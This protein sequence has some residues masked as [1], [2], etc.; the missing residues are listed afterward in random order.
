MN[1]KRF[2]GRD[3]GQALRAVRSSL[4]PDA[5][6]METKNLSK[7]LGGGIEITALAE[8]P[9]LN[10][11]DETEMEGVAEAAPLPVDEIREELAALRSMLRWLAPGINHAGTVSAVLLKHGFAP[12]TIAT[13]TE[14]MKSIH[15]ADDR[16]RLYRALA[17]LIP[18]GGQINAAGD[19]LAL[20]GPAGV[21]KTTTIIKLTIFET[22]RRSCR[23]GWV[24]TDQRRLVIGDP[25]A[26]YAGILGVHYETAANRKEL[27]QT[28][29][30]MTDLDLVLVDTAGV[31]PRDGA[32]M[33]EL[34]QL[35]H[36][37]PDLR[38]ALL[39]SAVTNGAD[40][41]D[42][43]AEYRKAALHS[44]IFT[45]IDE[46]RFLGPVVSTALSVG[47]PLSYV[48]LGQNFVGD[49]EV[50]KPAIFA[51]LILPGVD[52]HD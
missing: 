32:G 21:G 23:V 12:E 29:D 42:W 49:L 43:V 4:G 50:A 1:P 10:D 15:G 26:I 34:S 11:M 24:S 39:L 8:A 40:M 46:C 13:I 45:K 25:L 36:G 27:K 20:I 16:E 5:L 17:E 38:R 19:R 35:L 44:L 41:A 18:S 28:L 52:L 3:M 7:D 14:A 6:I 33:K 31:N 48:T 30:R 2:W 37:F 47:V 51:S 22:Q 9:G